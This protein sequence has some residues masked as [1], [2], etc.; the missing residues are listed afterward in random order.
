MSVGG[1]R[2]GHA[3]TTWTDSQ[4]YGSSG[5]ED[6][7]PYVGSTDIA[8]Q[9]VKQRVDIGD[10]CILI[11]FEV[12]GPSLDPFTKCADFESHGLFQV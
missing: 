5:A 6:G 8:A 2:C 12:A 11:R 9:L 1:G 3:P 4:E 7:F 10:Y